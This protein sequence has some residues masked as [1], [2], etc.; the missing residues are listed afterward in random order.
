MSQSWSL[1]AAYTATKYHRWIVGIP[2]SPN[3]EFFPISTMQ[4]RWAFKLN[5]NYNF[6]KAISLGGIVEV[7]NGV[8]GQRTYVFRATDAERPAAATAGVGD[9]S[10]RA[11][12]LAARRAADDVQRARVEADAAAE[13][14]HERQF[15]R[16]E[17]ASTPTRSPRRLMC[18]GRA[19]GGSRTFCRRA[20]SDSASSTTSNGT[21]TCEA[22]VRPPHA[23]LQ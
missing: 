2:Q 12:W 4:W 10:T 5:G 8:L 7:R 6:P 13:R 17:R 9:H 19:S 20:R 18:R 22:A 11:V 3:D 16:A 14:V 1:L 21:P 23:A 15:R